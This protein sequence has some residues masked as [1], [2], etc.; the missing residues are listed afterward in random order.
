MR[1]HMKQ[2][3]GAFAIGLLICPISAN[4]AEKVTL[5]FPSVLELPA[6]AAFQMAKYEGYYKDAG[7][8]VE[9]LAGHGGVDAATQVGAGN[10]DMAEALGDAPII[11]RSRGVPVRDVVVMGGG[12]LM[13]VAGRV[14]DGIKTLQDLKGKSM[15]VIAY[16]DTTYYTLLGV[17]G[18]VG[19]KKTDVDIQALGPT[20]VVQLFVN[21]NVQACACLPEW[22]VTAEDAGVKMNLM[23][24]AQYVPSLAQAI[25]ASDKIIK[26]RPEIV[27]GLVQATL[28]AYVQLRDTPV[29]AAKIYVAAVPVHKGKEEFFGRVFTYYSKF[30]WAGQKTT[31]VADP[32]VFQKVQD[33]YYDLGVI[34]SKSNV[35]DLYTNQ[36]VQPK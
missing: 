31:G 36:F 12:G 22:I 5:L 11:V 9:M 14:D 1:V 6:F 32:A 8:D 7:L 17:L 35:D 29:E 4:A 3:V 27:R 24:S 10:V 28:K 25:V 26:E 19:L 23:P 21:H 20:G 18:T 15:S 34:Q 2:L 13:T 16:Q 33:L 30:V